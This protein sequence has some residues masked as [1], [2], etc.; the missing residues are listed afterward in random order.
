M[1]LGRPLFGKTNSL[2]RP[3][4]WPINKRLT[5]AR[6]GSDNKHV[7]HVDIPSVYFLDGNPPSVLAGYRSRKQYKTFAIISEHLLIKAAGAGVG[8]A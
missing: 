6:K 4:P 7:A 8:N 3:E 5:L 1:P 2:E